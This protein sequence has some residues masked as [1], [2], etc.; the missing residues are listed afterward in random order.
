MK[1][2]A[3]NFGLVLA[4][5]G[6][7]PHFHFQ[8]D[9]WDNVEAQL[10]HSGIQFPWQTFYVSLENGVDYTSRIFAFHTLP[11]TAELKAEIV[12]VFPS[13]KDQEAFRQQYFALFK[14]VSAAGGLV[15]NEHNELLVIHR[16]GMLDLPKGKLEKGESIE[17]NAIREVAEETGITGHVLQKQLPSTYHIY[18]L[19]KWCLKT[20]YWFMMEVQ[21]AGPLSPQVEEEI[22]AAEWVKMDHICENLPDTY[23][24]IRE[25]IRHA[26][27]ELQR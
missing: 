4:V 21:G 15:I 7:N 20:T 13:E 14:E 22:F 16:R 10:T 8:T 3:N 25:T 1:I 5:S 27:V 24:T 9:S 6:S 2:F 26:C 18:E 17:E 19:G 23:P 12:L 11:K